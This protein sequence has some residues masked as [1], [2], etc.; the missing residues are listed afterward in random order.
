MGAG[1]AMAAVACRSA[2]VRAPSAPAQVPQSSAPVA[3]APLPA[4]TAQPA[5]RLGET[6]GIAIVAL[7]AP[8]F[9]TLPRDQRLV[10]WYASQAG[11]VG[12]AVA[13]EQG[14]R[15][16]LP[17]IRLLRGILSRPQVV[18]APLLGRI[19][20]FARL[21]YLN[22]GIHDAETGR[23]QLPGFSA[24]E[25]RTA[26]LAAA[27]A[28]ADLGLGGARL[29]YALRALEGPFFD[30][31]VDAQRTVHGADLTASAVNF[32]EGVTLRDL[33]GFTE[34]APLHSRL[35]KQGSTVVEQVYRLPAA[36]EALQ[37]ALPFSAP[38][39]R[40]V[41][42][43]LS[44]FFR[45]GDTAQFDA[46]ARAWTDAY[47]LVDGLAGFF[48][49]SA[50]PRGRK[51]LFGAMVGLADP[52]R[53]EALERLQL[54]NSGEALFLLSAAGA[55]R[56]PQ[57]YA[58]TADGK[59]AVFASALEAA[60]Q[61]RADPAMAALAEPH[62]VQELLRCGPALRFAQLSLRE[63][64]RT[65]PDALA[66]LDEALADA[67]ASALAG[68]TPEILPDPACRALWPAFVT[69][70]WLA[71]TAAAPEERIE[72]DRQRA[73]QLQLWW[74]TGKGAV[75]E[76]HAGGRRFLA[77]PDVARFQAAAQE[78][79]GLL[80]EVR[81]SNDAA[82]WR[83]LLDR[84]ASQADPRWRAEAA[85]RLAGLPRRVAVLPP[86]LE[87]VLDGD[88]KVVDAQ[89]A[90]VQDLDGQILRDWAAY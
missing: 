46:A 64:S 59:S 72:E 41:F 11:A 39:Q 33:Q 36:A 8:Q 17:V 49:R 74:F 83:E 62:Q 87:A 78:L 45:S 57:T 43:P 88:G 38:P 29:E 56:P 15:G 22:H 70:G 27:A 30:P 82:R 9:A 60:A 79:V 1:L 24:A 13:A 35:V 86:R 18:P 84:H 71:S 10:A 77:V 2:P 50:D 12:D 61:V 53:T 4:F 90:P 5:T 52:E 85:G 6:G 44:A 14:Y 47:G 19:R 31:R 37:R 81:T 51:A 25:L 32:Y 63:L 48:D 55:L 42:E 20:G 23:K 16:N 34:Q 58:L 76:R 67:N 80:N 65:P 75:V 3:A 89:A 21:V 73:V 40:A 7:G 26:A 68:A 54:R 66:A 69:S 28:G